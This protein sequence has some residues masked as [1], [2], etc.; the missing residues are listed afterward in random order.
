M[1]SLQVV[2][3]RHV[4]GLGQKQHRGSLTLL[5]Q[6]AVGVTG[7]NAEADFLSESDNRVQALW[8][9]LVLSEAPWLTAPYRD[10]PQLPISAPYADS[11]RTT[12]PQRRHT[13]SWLRTSGPRRPGGSS[14]RPRCACVPHPLR[15]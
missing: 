13:S 12:R 3:I 7:L 9:Q 11:D 2:P 5:L 15:R 8:P 6:A 14:Q 1:L 4:E 10:L